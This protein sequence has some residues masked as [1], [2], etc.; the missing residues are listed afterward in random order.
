MPK[1][2]PPVFEEILQHAILPDLDRGRKNFDRPH[3]EAVVFWMKYILNNTENDLDPYVMIPAA[4][5]HDWGYIG[6]FDGFNSDDP[7]E[8][9]KQKLSHMDRG[10]EKVKHLLN[11]SCSQF[12]NSQQINE[13]AHLVWIHDKV[14]SLKGVDEISIME[15]DTLGMIDVD[16]VKPTF[17]KAD[18]ERFVNKEVINWRLPTFIHP[19][20]RKIGLILAHKRLEYG[21]NFLV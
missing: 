15:A 17:S 19:E 2:I 4:Y 9:A 10:A 1:S 6:L 7:K 11:S 8:I 12:V 5:A 18:N 13:T 16:R 3:T 14:D 21:N 20:I